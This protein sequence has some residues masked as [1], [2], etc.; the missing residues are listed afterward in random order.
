[1]KFVFPHPLRFVA[2]MWRTFVV[3]L[4]GNDVVASEWTQTNRRMICRTCP[5]LLESGQCQKCSCFVAMKTILAEE[6]CPLGKW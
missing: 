3:L 5:L 1:M 4:W 2:A 6:Q